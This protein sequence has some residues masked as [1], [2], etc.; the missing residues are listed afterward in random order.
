MSPGR[1]G[2]IVALALSFLG[3]SAQAQ[4]APTCSFDQPSATVTVIVNG[5]WATL[6]VDTFGAIEMNGIDC[7]QG[8]NVTSVDRI[9]VTGRGLADTLVVTGPERFAPGKT[10]E[11]EGASEIEISPSSSVD[12]IHFAADGVDTGS[13]GDADLTTV[14]VETLRAEASEIDASLYAGGAV[15]LLFGERGNDTIRGSAQ[16]D[17]LYGEKGNDALYGGGG[18]DLLYGGTGNDLF[19]GGDGNDAFISLG[20]VDG[21]DT[22]I[23]GTGMDTVDYTA[24]NLGVN[25]TIGNGLADDGQPGVEFDAV[26]VSVENANGGDGDDVIVGSAAANLIDGGGGNDELYGGG[27]RDEIHGGAGDDILVGDAGRDNLYGDAGAD[28]VDGGMGNDN[29]YGGTGTDAL[30]GGAGLDDIFGEGA[31]DLIY[32]SDGEADNVDCG[33][34]T[35]DDAEVDALDTLT[36]CE[37]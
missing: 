16:A 4:T 2:S 31:S 36:G 37:I 12:A 22:F 5:L 18:D 21:N 33:A 17:F 29:L 19:D 14:N 11:D 23:G 24:R 32:N 30:T 9:V 26:D 35:A 13:D 34:G 7:A 27:G 3:S 28:S 25:V 20:V 1:S 6:S 8:A 10:S 15:L